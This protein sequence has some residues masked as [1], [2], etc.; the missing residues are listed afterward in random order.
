ML[1]AAYSL[2]DTAS[3]RRKSMSFSIV[4]G[5]EQFL[6]SSPVQSCPVLCPRPT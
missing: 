2:G 3:S 6:L 4:K 1:S 5:A